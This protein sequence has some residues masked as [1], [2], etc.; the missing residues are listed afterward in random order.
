MGLPNKTLILSAKGWK[1]YLCNAVVRGFGKNCREK[2]GMGFQ[3]IDFLAQNKNRATNFIQ[4]DGVS[5]KVNTEVSLPV[6]VRL[7][8]AVDLKLIC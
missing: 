1:F 5:W 2:I 7:L 3:I 4:G 6:T 8:V